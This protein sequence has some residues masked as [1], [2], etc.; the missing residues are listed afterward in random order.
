MNDRDGFVSL[1]DGGR[2]YFRRVG[3]GANPVVIPG[4][5]LLAE[6]LL[7]LAGRRQVIFYCQRG[8]GGS[9]RV[10]NKSLV[11]TE[12]ETR[13]L[14]A[15]RRHFQLGAMALLGWSYLGGVIALYAL[16]HPERV[17][18]LILMCPIPPRLPNP[19]VGTEEL[20]RQSE[21]RVDPQ[22][23]KKLEEMKEAGL[24]RE[25]PVAFCQEHNR[26]HF[27]RQMAKPEAL[28][29]MR[30][31]PC[32][33]PN[34]WPGNLEAHWR[35]HFPPES[36]EF[37]WRPQLKRIQA[38]VLVIHGEEDFP[39]GPS[40]EW[41]RG[42]PEARLLT[43]EECG[44]FPHLEAPDVFFPAVETFLAGRWPDAATKAA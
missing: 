27:P 19:S 23:L 18:R 29:R 39:A 11:W 14:E 41:V 13:D 17:H 44:H 31:T 12:Y 5:T 42:L 1:D 40:L 7:P 38:P 24:E 28:A 25:D 35:M 36:M 20:D 2:L 3:S 34:E 21:S 37:D 16:E 26:V 9:D 43:I 32:A 15:V 33:Y 8:R 10:G 30:S 4:A 6:D 22:K